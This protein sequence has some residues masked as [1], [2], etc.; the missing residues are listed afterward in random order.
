MITSAC[1][2]PPVHI[3]LARDTEMLQ[4]ADHEIYHEHLLLKKRGIPLWVPGPSKN[5]PPEYR[6]K[7]IAFGDV[8]ILHHSGEFDF[9]FNVFLPADH[10]INRAGVP[11]SF[12]PLDPKKVE[13]DIEQ[14]PLYGSYDYLACSTLTKIGNYSQPSVLL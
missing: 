3:E 8:G 12:C 1:H 14:N 11:E 6:R 7:G 4:M 9:L 13:H 2:L 10:P 5:L